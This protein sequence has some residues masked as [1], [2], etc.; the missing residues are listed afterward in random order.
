MEP[1]LLRVGDLD[2]HVTVSEKR[3]TVGLTVERDSTITAMV[4][5]A[6]EEAALAKVITAKGPWLHSKLR[7][8][9]ET[10]TPR[11]P[12]EYVSGEG[13][14]YLGRS[15]RLL[16]VDESPVPVRLVRGRLL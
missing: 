7:E 15:Y 16:V 4:P 10:G 8:R 2:V 12:R 13:F 6:L 9:A 5:P 14:S 1:G 11:P 3:R